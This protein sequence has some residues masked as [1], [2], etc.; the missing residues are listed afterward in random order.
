MKKLLRCFDNLKFSFSFRGWFYEALEDRQWVKDK[1]EVDLIKH[2]KNLLTRPRNKK[3]WLISG[4][5]NFKSGQ[6]LGP[7]PIWATSDLIN[8]LSISI[9]IQCYVVDISSHFVFCLFSI[10]HSLFS[11]PAFLWVTSTFF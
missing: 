9:N 11:F 10:F 5:A 7:F 2:K 1:I 8:H 3:F 6:F 4:L